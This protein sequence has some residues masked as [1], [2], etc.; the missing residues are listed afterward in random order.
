MWICLDLQ[1][2]GEASMS[3]E[4][5]S[6]NTESVLR[7]NETKANHML[8]LI[9]NVTILVVAVTWLLFESGFFYIRIHFRALMIFNIVLMGIASGISRYFKY[10]KKW[11]KY[12]LM[13][14]LTVVYAGTTSALTYNVALLIVIPIILSVRY[15]SKRYTMFIA[16]LSI[17]VFFISYLYGANHGMLDLN[18]VQYAPGTTIVTND[19][20]WLDDAVRNIPYNE[21]LMLQNT[22]ISNY[23]V[24]LLQYVVQGSEQN[25]I[26]HRTSRTACSQ[27]FSR[28]S[29]RGKNSRYMH[30]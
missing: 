21:T 9:L 16:V 15:F 5:V 25:S 1:A 14:T 30:R 17:V 12:L 26:W 7:E 8:T 13:G 18:F 2:Y 24:K 3:K 22:M 19:K 29:P 6:A 20:M 27:I 10:E 28:H 23:F 4:G 11:I